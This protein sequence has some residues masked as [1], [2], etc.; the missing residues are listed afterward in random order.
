MFVKGIIMGQAKL[1]GS[2][3][4]R[5]LQSQIREAQL[6]LIK[7][8]EKKRLKEQEAAEEARILSTKTEEEQLEYFR[9]KKA[10]V[11]KKLQSTAMLAGLAAAMISTNTNF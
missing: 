7:E 5:I 2:K 1:R 8:G 9:D 10:K 6:K 11:T 3:E 4:A